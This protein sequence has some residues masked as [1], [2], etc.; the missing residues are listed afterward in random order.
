MLLPLNLACFYGTVCLLSQTLLQAIAKRLI[1]SQ[2][3]PYFLQITHYKRPTNSVIP[4]KPPSPNVDAGLI[5]CH[6]EF[7]TTLIR[8]KGG[9]GGGGEQAIQ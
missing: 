9:G 3:L 7:R 1:H 6:R 2:H 4:F 5:E 8:G